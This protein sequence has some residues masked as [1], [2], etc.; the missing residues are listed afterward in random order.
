MLL[1]VCVLAYMLFATGGSTPLPVY[2][3]ADGGT[4]RGQ[5]R[6]AKKHGLGVYRYPG[7]G[8]YEGMWRNNVKD[9]FGVYSFPKVCRATVLRWFRKQK[10]HQDA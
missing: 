4:Y 1:T 5:W 2:E 8:K 3:H 7:G 9:G 6:G 10:G